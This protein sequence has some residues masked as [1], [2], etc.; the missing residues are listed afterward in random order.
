MIAGITVLFPVCAVTWVTGTS[1]VTQN[2]RKIP[3]EDK[4]VNSDHKKRKPIAV[5]IQDTIGGTTI[6][7][8]LGCHI[9]MITK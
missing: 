7:I 2:E 9:C 5:T 6:E 1:G 3:E 8:P 4:H